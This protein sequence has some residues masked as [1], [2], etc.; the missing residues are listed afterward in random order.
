MNYSII[1]HDSETA[2]NNISLIDEF[3]IKNIKAVEYE[4]DIHQILLHNNN[5]W[6]GIAKKNGGKYLKVHLY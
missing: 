4:P 2:L 6:H 3:K 1:F 5:K